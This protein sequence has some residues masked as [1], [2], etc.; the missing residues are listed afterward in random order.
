MLSGK[1]WTSK[2]YQFKSG[3]HEKMKKF[4]FLALVF[5]QI[6]LFAGIVDTVSIPSQAMQKEIK[7]VVVIP[8]KYSENE[9]ISWPVIYLLHGWSGKYSDWAKKT[10]LGIMADKYN[11]IIVCPDGGYAGWYLDS[12]IKKDSQYETYIAS[13]VVKYIDENYKTIKE[14]IGRFITGLS[15]GGQGAIRLI[16]KYPE[17]YSAA[18]SMSGVMDLFNAKI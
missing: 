2:I 9:Y 10:D 11:F 3:G 4:L 8:D 14:P 17:L 6:S 18:G 16:V 13:E 7:A 1:L 5:V 12:A 15:M